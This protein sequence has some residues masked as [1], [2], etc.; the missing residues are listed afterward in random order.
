MFVIPSNSSAVL[1]NYDGYTD[2]IIGSGG[3]FYDL[4]TD[5]IWV[6]FNTYF[7]NSYNTIEGL[8][9]GSA[10][11]FAV[12]SEVEAVQSSASS[13]SFMDLLNIMGG[14]DLVPGFEVISGVYDD[15][16]TDAFVSEY[17][18]VVGTPWTSTGSVIDP[19]GFGPA[20]GG[21]IVNTNV[22]PEPTTMLLLGVGLIGLAGT[23]RKMKI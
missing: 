10:F 17:F 19:D 18:R 23:R 20:I 7:N 5:Y 16:G 3:Y 21:W 15:G 13:Q 2:P 6:D 14:W 1:I 22:V 9:T 8:L 11:R 4:E 12:E